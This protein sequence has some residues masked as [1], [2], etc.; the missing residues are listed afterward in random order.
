MVRVDTLDM[1]DQGQRSPYQP[2]PSYLVQGARPPVNG[3]AIGAFIAV[4]F[5]SIVGLV[6]GYVA[7]GQIKQTGE[8]GRGLALAA[9]ILGWISVILTVLLVVGFIAGS[10]VFKLY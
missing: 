9:V 1:T 7:L 10:A 6:L 4:F 3:M 8:G 2:Q 5:V